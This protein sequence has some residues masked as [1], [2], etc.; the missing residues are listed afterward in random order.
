MAWSDLKVRRLILKWIRAETGSQW[1]CFKRGA[2]L[3]RGLENV[4]TRA[5]VF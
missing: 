2:V 5:S 4:T 1:R 3:D